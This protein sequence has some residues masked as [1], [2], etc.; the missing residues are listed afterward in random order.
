MKD[1]R[2]ESYNTYPLRA[3][4]REDT[5]GSASVLT[6]LGPGD[7]YSSPSSFGAKNVWNYTPSSTKFLHGLA[8]N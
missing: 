8:T 4:L 1:I 5:G 7:D 2:T 6:R 3:S